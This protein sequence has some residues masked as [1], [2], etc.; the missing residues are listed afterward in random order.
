[1]FSEKRCFSEKTM[2]FGGDGKQI[3]YVGVAEIE[4]GNANSF[5]QVTFPEML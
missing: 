4:N 2:I 1:M 3:C 5:P